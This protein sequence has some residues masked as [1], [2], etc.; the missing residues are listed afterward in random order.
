MNSKQHPPLWGN[1]VGH[2]DEDLLA[3]A[4]LW[5]GGLMLP[6]YYHATQAVEK[7][8]KALCLSI[9]DPDGSKE[10]AANKKWI[11]THDLGALAKRCQERFPYYGEPAVV[12]ELQRLS[13]FD[14]AT[15]YPWVPRKH[16][17][18]FSGDDL[19][20]FCALISHLRTDIPIQ[21]DDYLLGILIR[22]FHHANPAFA[23]NEYLLAQRKASVMALQ[24][25]WP[26]VKKIV[27]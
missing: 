13:E 7:Y 23:V 15:R 1:F 2:A 22:G 9:I 26:D 24:Q 18:G 5:K 11:I 20:V 12:T 14:Q 25:L 21:V 3:F 17:S 19:A 10:T 6:A 8:F 16:G 4:W 27:R